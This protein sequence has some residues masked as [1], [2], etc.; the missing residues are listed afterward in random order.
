MDNGTGITDKQKKGGPTS[1]DITK[2]EKKRE[3][4]RLAKIP[5]PFAIARARDRKRQPA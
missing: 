4:Q 3:E 1:R 5:M 2:R